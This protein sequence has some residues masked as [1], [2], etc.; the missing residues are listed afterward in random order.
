[1]V[2]G[3]DKMSDDWELFDDWEL[4][5]D[6]DKNDSDKRFDG[7]NKLFDGSDK[8]FDGSDKVFEF[9]DKVFDGSDRGIDGSE[10]MIDAIVIRTCLGRRKKVELRSFREF[11]RN[12]MFFTVLMSFLLQW[13]G[14]EKNRRLKS[15]VIGSQHS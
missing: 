8:V 9:S 5:D 15:N 2:D 1:M 7:S 11:F 14:S 10:E 13:I 4:S 12:S 3:S 6:S